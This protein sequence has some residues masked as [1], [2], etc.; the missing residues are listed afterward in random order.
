MITQAQ[1]EAMLKLAEALEACERN[2][3]AIAIPGRSDVELQNGFSRYNIDIS[4]FSELTA[5]SVRLAVNA[6][7]QK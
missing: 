2:G 7:V 4:Q 3:L 5:V 6:L 1:A